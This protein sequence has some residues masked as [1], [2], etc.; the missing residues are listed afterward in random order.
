VRCFIDRSALGGYTPA[1]GARTD[2]PGPTMHSSSTRCLALAFATA[3][4]HS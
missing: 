2:N 3:M 4:V 1:N